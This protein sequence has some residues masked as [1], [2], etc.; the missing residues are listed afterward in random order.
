VKYTSLRNRVAAAEERLNLGGS[1]LR[2]SG[3]LP[4]GFKMPAAEP[5]G[6]DLKRQ[7]AMF[8]QRPPAQPSAEPT[9]GQEAAQEAAQGPAEPVGA[10]KR[11]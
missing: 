9:T 4:P 8:G 2:I 5:P 10:A 1:K 6:A 7:A 11:A 3:G